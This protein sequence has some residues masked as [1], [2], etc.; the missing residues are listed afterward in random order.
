MSRRISVKLSGVQNDAY[1]NGKLTCEHLYIISDANAQFDGEVNYSTVLYSGA[2]SD[3]PIMLNYEANYDLYTTAASGIVPVTDAGNYFSFY[4]REY[5]EYERMEY[6]PGS[7]QVVRQTTVFKGPWEPVG[8]H[9]NTGFLRDFNVTSGRSYQYI[10]YP[11]TTD[12][13]QQFANNDDFK[14]AH[15]TGAPVITNWDEWSLTELIPINEEDS[16]AP[17]VSKRY[18]A[19]IDNVWLFKYALETGT[20]TQNMDYSEVK[21]LGPFPR[22]N[23]GASNYLSGDVS[24]LLGSEIIPYSKNSYIERLRGAIRT[25]LSTNERIKM[26]QQWRTIANSR[27]PKLLKDIKGQSWIVRIMS[28]SNTPKNFYPGQPDVISFSWRQIEDTHNVII[29][30]APDTL[31]DKNECNSEWEPIKK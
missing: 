29:Y 11:E 26:L 10:I 4:R 17:I 19:D 27:N 18:K 13:R 20:Q 23:N 14:T 28:S 3:S 16:D 6:D 8:I 25:P 15:I 5:Q 9:V 2:R 21:T 1:H 30:G 22:I 12:Q 24:C 7:G 31:P